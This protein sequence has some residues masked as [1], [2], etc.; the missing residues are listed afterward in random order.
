MIFWQRKFD[1]LLTKYTCLLCVTMFCFFLSFNFQCGRGIE[2]S[3]FSLYFHLALLLLYMSLSLSSTCSLRVLPPFSVFPSSF[4]LHCSRALRLSSLF[5]E[6]VS[7]CSSCVVSGFRVFATL[8]LTLVFALSVLMCFLLWLNHPSFFHYTHSS[9]FHVLLI[10][11]FIDIKTWG[12]N[13]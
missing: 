2:K 10:N 12:G 6:L 1:R 3:W 4:L 13:K 7:L 11:T 9:L 5:H 8:F